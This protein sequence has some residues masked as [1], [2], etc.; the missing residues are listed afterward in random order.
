M[1]YDY[2][3]HPGLLMCCDILKGAILL[4]HVAEVITERDLSQQIAMSGSR[5]RPRH[6]LTASVSNG[7]GHWVIPPSSTLLAVD[8][9][10]T[11]TH[12]HWN[13]VRSGL[14]VFVE[15]QI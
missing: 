10:D 8:V 2:G 12:P 15:W 5:A 6:W 11:A 3:D 4:L 7:Q 13:I 1:N 9:V 14:C